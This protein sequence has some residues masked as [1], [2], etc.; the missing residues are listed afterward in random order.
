MVTSNKLG[1]MIV[2]ALRTAGI[3][4]A[5]YHGNNSNWE[6]T[7]YGVMTHQELKNKEFE[8]VNKYWTNY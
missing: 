8:D 5:F 2:D 3:K 1:A 6:D 4:C 7:L